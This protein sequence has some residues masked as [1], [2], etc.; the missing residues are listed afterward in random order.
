MEMQRV[1]S[2]LAPTKAP[3]HL[4]SRVGSG[5]RRSTSPP[6]QEPLT[7]CTV[8]PAHAACRLILW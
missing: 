7:V 8:S 3:S 5:P 4:H 6:S 1:A 2:Y